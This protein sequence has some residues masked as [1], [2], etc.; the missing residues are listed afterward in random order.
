[1]TKPQFYFHGSAY[2]GNTYEVIIHNNELYYLNCSGGLPSQ[3]PIRIE[4]SKKK[5]MNFLESLEALR[6]SR[7]KVWENTMLDGWCYDLKINLPGLKKKISGYVD[8]DPEVENC[9]TR[10]KRLHRD[11]RKET[12]EFMN[13]DTWG[14]KYFYSCNQ[15]EYQLYMA[16][17]L[18]IYEF[19]YTVPRECLNCHIIFDG[20]DDRRMY[21]PDKK[22]LRCSKC[23]QS[24]TRLWDVEARAC[25]KCGNGKLEQKQNDH[26]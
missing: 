12:P 20:P 5:L 10:M 17:N 19:G 11:M 3:F 9:V 1:M 21:I 26:G 18:S 23:D 13:P 6:N 15:C 8:Y 2:F 24:N 25:P 4:V 22:V 7:E 14:P 16:G